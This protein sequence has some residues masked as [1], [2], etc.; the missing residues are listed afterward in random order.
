M[1]STFEMLFEIIGPSDSLYTGVQ[2][3]TKKIAEITYAPEK[4]IVIFGIDYPPVRDSPQLKENVGEDVKVVAKLVYNPSIY[5]IPFALDLLK[6]TQDLVVNFDLYKVKQK[7]PF[8][9]TSNVFNS[10]IVAPISPPPRPEPF[11]ASKP[12]DTSPPVTP[13]C[14]YVNGEKI[15]STFDDDDEILVADAVEY[16]F[17]PASRPI[18]ISLLV[19]IF[20]L[21]I[22]IIIVLIAIIRKRCCSAKRRPVLTNFAPLTLDPVCF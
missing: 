14:Y 8:E 2:A 17:D 15:C 22:A 4:S 18:I 6:A 19:A 12:S 3:M 20:G 21:V 7:G 16:K 13:V 5:D 9:I 1:S 11:H 10:T